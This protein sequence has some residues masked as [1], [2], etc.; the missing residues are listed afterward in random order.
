M[1]KDAADLDLGQ[2]QHLKL[3]PF[4]VCHK[5]SFTDIIYY[6]LCR[7]TDLTGFVAIGGIISIAFLLM[8]WVWSVVPSLSDSYFDYEGRVKRSRLLLS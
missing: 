8:K 6:T 1:L 7:W 4:Q 2:A 3:M 5:L